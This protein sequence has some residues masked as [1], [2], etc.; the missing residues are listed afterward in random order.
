MTDFSPIKKLRLKEDFSG[1]ADFDAVN[2]ENDFLNRLFEVNNNRGTIFV[3]DNKDTGHSTFITDTYGIGSTRILKVIKSIN[4][5]VFLWHIDG[6]MYKKGSKC[7]CA[8]LD[9]KIL[10]FV[11]FKSEAL[12]NSE[13]KISA[14]ANYEKCQKQIELMLDE[15]LDKCKAIGIN[16][17]SVVEVKALAVFNKTVPASNATKTSFKRRFE[18]K[19]KGV[20]FEF[21][22]EIKM[23]SSCKYDEASWTTP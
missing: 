11:E 17:M 9:N 7:D 22:N 13:S 23:F 12:K 15:V 19:H 1:Q 16:V 4:H 14:K 18:N 3:F 6:I 2:T 10:C 21:A 5:D 20:T 8:L